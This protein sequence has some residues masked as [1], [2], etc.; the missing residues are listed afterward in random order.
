[1]IINNQTPSYQFLSPAL[2]KRSKAQPETGA[3]TSA[4]NSQSA[5]SADQLA[6]SENNFTAAIPDMDAAKSSL[7]FARKSIIGQPNLAMLA[8]ANSISPEALRLLQ[9]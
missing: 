7:E 6:V 4:D 3:A 5:P 9:Q 1:M 2:A 8:Q